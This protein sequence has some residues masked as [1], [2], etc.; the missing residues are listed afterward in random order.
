[1]PAVS[2]L[3]VGQATADRTKLLHLLIEATVLGEGECCR[4]R[5]VNDSPST[6]ANDDG[7]CAAGIPVIEWSALHVAKPTQSV[8]A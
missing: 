4:E 1:M 2:M 5:S 3:Q 8:R 6:S 7:R